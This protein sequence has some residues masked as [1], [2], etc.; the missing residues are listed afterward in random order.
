MPSSTNSGPSRRTVLRSSGLLG[1]AAG[2]GFASGL[3]AA[4]D[5]LSSPEPARTGREG[6]MTNVPFEGFDEVRVGLVGVGNRGLGQARRW[7]AVSTVTA[8]ADIR[9]GQAEQAADRIVQESGQTRP[10]I[11]ANGEEDYLNLLKRDDIDL[12]Y[13]ATPW[14]WHHPM[15]K[16]AMEHGKHVVVELPIAPYLN[17]IWDLVRTSERTR[18]HC[19][20][21]EN[22]CYFRPELR[23]LMMSKQGLF[24]DLLHGSG[25]YVH[26]LRDPYMFHGAY[27]PEGWRRLWHTRMNA[28]HYPMHGLG[29]ISAAMDINRGDRFDRLVSIASPA[30]GLA[31]YREENMP[32]DHPSWGEKYISG[33]RNTCF[34]QTVNGRFIR[35]EHEVTTPH[36]YT[37]RTTLVGTRGV[38]D[39]NLGIY[40]E[41][42]GHNNHSWRSFGSEFAEYDHWL[43]KDI[44][45][46][47]EEY[48]GHG[49]GD[50]ISIFRTIQLM[51][52]G[53][54]P[55]IDVYDSAAWCAVIELSEKSLT[56]GSR[57]VKVPDFTRGHWEEER[58]GLSRD[59][60]ESSEQVKVAATGRR[61]ARAGG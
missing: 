36:P 11:Y 26:D 15:A 46:S 34:I 25:G 3:P 37:R 18:K 19:M 54:T 29:P 50:F 27:Y 41:T 31:L 52:L 48:G 20:L 39:E 1:A 14:E 57:A 30:M 59:R 8:I 42:L 2:L 60:P 32:P 43:W 22:V 16:A 47:A 9:R 12:V 44:G 23:A 45:D 21:L 7:A 28:S 51:R 49:G 38:W 56:A 10:A 40:L 58:Q 24:G 53:L 6:T 55:D 33:D 17:E 4:A 35:V 5:E 61:G 13:V